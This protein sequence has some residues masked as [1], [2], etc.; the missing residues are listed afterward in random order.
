LFTLTVH[1]NGDNT[2]NCSQWR[3]LTPA[4]SINR[5]G[6]GCS[7]K[8]IHF[9]GFITSVPSPNW[10]FNVAVTEWIKKSNLIIFQRN[11]IDEN[12]LDAIRYWQGLGKPC[13]ID[14]DDSYTMLPISNPAYDF[15]H[16]EHK[17]AL[18]TLV[19][20]I[21]ISDGL[22]AP[23][24]NLL[25]DFNTLTGCRGYY[26][27]NYAEKE[28]WTELSDKADIRKEKG[29]PEDRLI[30]GWGGSISHY[31]SFHGSSI[32][33]ALELLCARYP[34]VTIMICG[35]DTRLY[36]QLKIPQSQKLHHPGVNPDQWPR[37]VKC[38][39]IGIA[40]LFWDYDQRRSWIKGMEYLLAGVPW[41]GTN[42]GI[43]GTYSD[44]RDLGKLIYNTKLNW[45]NALEDMVLR[46]DE[47]RKISESRIEM[48]REKFLA[49][50]NTDIMV[51]TYRQII[52]DWQES[53]RSVLLPGVA[54][55]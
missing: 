47:Y 41:V 1:R 37:A 30:I 49:D 43:N 14:L 10:T 12:C 19:E 35:N 42:G 18:H 25:N 40:P 13:C 50:N 20:G 11:V 46:I 39:D 16:G 28:W 6:N 22:I 36:E 23:N 3:Q 29:I 7:A 38:F 26:I 54:R 33:D 51:G 5:N 32:F 2:Y 8:L 48:A 15:W 27:Q 52:K 9:S 31:D 34:Q 45:F 17:E 24:R 4:D 55:I 21:R 44:L 53:K